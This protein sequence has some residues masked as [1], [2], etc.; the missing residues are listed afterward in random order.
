MAIGWISILVAAAC[1]RPAVQDAAAT[2]VPRDA[3][4]TGSSLP[5]SGT[6]VPSPSAARTVPFP[7]LGVLVGTSDGDVYT[8]LAGGRPAGTKVHVCDGSI[9]RLEVAATDLVSCIQGSTFAVFTF[10]HRTGAVA[11]VAGVDGPAIWTLTGDAILY[12]TRGSCAPGA[13]DCA[14]RLVRRD[15]RTAA[16]TTIDERVGV[17]TDFRSTEEG[18]TI[19]RAKNSVTFIR[20]EAEAGT[21]VLR[22]TTLMRFSASRLV[23]GY[24][25]RWLLESE[26]T[27]SFNSG[28][29]TYVIQRLQ[30]ETRLTPANVEN[31]RAV[32]MLN[33]GRI[34]AYRPDGDGPDGTM[35]I[36]SATGG[37]VERTDRG[38]FTPFQIVRATPDWILG[39][40]YAGAPSLTL[41]A[42]R[43]SDG[44]FAAVPGGRISAVAILPAK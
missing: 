44:A 5:P 27:R 41:R 6:V 8:K 24:K 32:T 18:P 42:Y 19:W 34:V 36:Y 40:E 29:C 38:S 20:P 9:V 7:D 23:A 30:D 16:L 2:P 15:M 11:R 10:D 21:Y 4:R 14:T 12:V 3:A 22:D 37:R 1:G 17:L 43:V 31:E 35:V 26:E 28:C 13:A 25:G 33:D 39:F